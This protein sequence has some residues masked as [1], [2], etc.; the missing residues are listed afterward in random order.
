MLFQFYNSNERF[1]RRI[2]ITNMII[3]TIIYE[4]NLIYI[5]VNLYN[6]KK[7]VDPNIC[8]CNVC[9]VCA[10]LCIFSKFQSLKDIRV[11]HFCYNLKNIYL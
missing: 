9:I 10:P 8:F 2:Q 1:L 3:S 6:T 5:V 11:F 7:Q 4:L